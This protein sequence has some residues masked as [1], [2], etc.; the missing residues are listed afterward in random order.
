M[1]KSSL[2][3]FILLAAMLAHSPAQAAWNGQLSQ[4]RFAVFGMGSDLDPDQTGAG[5]GVSGIWNWTGNVFLTGQLFLT[6]MDDAD[7]AQLL[8]GGEWQD[9]VGQ[10]T[11]YV[12]LQVGLDAFDAANGSQEDAF[13][14]IYYDIGWPVLANSELRLGAGYDTKTGIIERQVALR[15]AWT[16][17]LDEE[18]T[19]FVR[20]ELYDEER[21]VMAGVSWGF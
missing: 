7:R 9:H 17:V 14:R 1:K 13:G 10:F 20:T 8:L 6:T 15:A 3:L 11:G 21:N 16:T 19:F 12:G 2:A 4:D 18:K 5:A